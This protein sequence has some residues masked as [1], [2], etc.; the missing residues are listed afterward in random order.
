M[1]RGHQLKV[2]KATITGPQI[3][4]MISNEESGGI[5]PFN[6]NSSVFCCCTEVCGQTEQHQL[7]SPDV[8]RYFNS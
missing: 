3:A 6:R 7:M 5:V 2:T 8:I 1:H 4:A